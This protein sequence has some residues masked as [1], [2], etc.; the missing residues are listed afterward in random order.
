VLSALE[1]GYQEH[2]QEMIYLKVDPFFDQLHSDPR[3]QV[4]L[5]GMG[6]LQ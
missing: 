6:F 1:H 2:D 3:F 4:L 5:R